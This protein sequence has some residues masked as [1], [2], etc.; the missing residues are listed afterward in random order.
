MFSLVFN[1]SFYIEIR[2]SLFPSQIFFF[3]YTFYV[4]AM[5]NMA[6]SALGLYNL[7]WFNFLSQSLNGKIL[8]KF[9]S[10]GACQF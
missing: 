4:C 3:L 2:Y 6:V 5:V 7:F 1:L 10:G 9:F 8:F